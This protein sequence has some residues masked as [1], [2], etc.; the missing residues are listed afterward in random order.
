MLQCKCWDTWV[1]VK[2]TNDFVHF[3]G[4]TMRDDSFYIRY[5]V[6]SGDHQIWR[7]ILRKRCHQ[8]STL[9]RLV[10]NNNDSVKILDSSSNLE[11]GGGIVSTSRIS[12]AK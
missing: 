8:S 3:G 10:T 9:K 6:I 11:K 5:D 2:P 4:V 7:I 12:L 1:A